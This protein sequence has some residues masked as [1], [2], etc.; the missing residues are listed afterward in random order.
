MAFKLPTGVAEWHGDD[1]SAGRPAVFC[2][3]VW[4][5][6]RDVARWGRWALFVVVSP[7]ALVGMWAATLAS[8]ALLIPVLI[9]VNWCRVDP[10][11]PRGPG[12]APLWKCV[13]IVPRKV[14][15]GLIPPRTGLFSQVYRI[16]VR[17]W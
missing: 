11:L 4:C 7:F 2:H 15:M 5:L 16:I 1:R 17:R 14:R 9:L 6:S 12:G 3:Q 13:L 10:L 8:L